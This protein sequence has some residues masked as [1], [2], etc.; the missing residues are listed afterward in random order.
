MK[1]GHPLRS[2][3]LNFQNKL[4]RLCRDYALR[5]E[6]SINPMYFNSY[7][8]QIGLRVM[9]DDFTSEVATLITQGIR[10]SIQTTLDKLLKKTRY[11]LGESERLSLEAKIEN[12]LRRKYVGKTL[13][14]RLNTS[15]RFTT[16]RLIQTYRLIQAGLNPSW[17][18][19]FFN[20]GQ[21]VFFW[22]NR[23]LTTE[24]LRAY[25][26]TVR[27]F[28]KHTKAKEIEFIFDERQLKRRSEYRLLA[29]G[30]PYKVE[31]LP[32]YPRPYASYILEIIY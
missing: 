3:I 6:D 1:Q 18:D 24:M 9:G 15:Q 27:E 14:E 17:S 28:A 20:S 2:K 7:T 10:E 11:S 32:D 4:D 5:V 8:D 12:Q 31:N 21:S 13:N 23:L 22:N 25:H 26:Y 30:G 19:T 29:D 16:S